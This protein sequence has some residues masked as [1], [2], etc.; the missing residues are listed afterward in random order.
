MQSD[1]IHKLNDRRAFR[2]D[3]GI[4]TN[5]RHNRSFRFLPISNQIKMKPS[6]F[7]HFFNPLLGQSNVRSLFQLSLPEF[8]A[9]QMAPGEVLLDQLSSSF[10][11]DWTMW[12]IK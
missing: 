8:S 12:Y 6:G 4:N 10:L 1:G 3:S 7:D 2:T 5:G 11:A 9:L